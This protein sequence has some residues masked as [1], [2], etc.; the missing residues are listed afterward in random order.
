MTAETRRTKCT[1]SMDLMYVDIRSAHAVSTD[2]L[3]AV[4]EGLDPVPWHRA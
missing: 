4:E 2:G 3:H 1:G